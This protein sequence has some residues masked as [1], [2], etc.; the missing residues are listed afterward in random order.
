[1]AAILKN[2]NISAMD[3]P[4]LTKFGT[5]PPTM[6]ANKIL[7]IQKSKMADAVILKKKKNRN[8]SAIKQQI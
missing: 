6:M 2:L 7:W 1:M 3:C 5:S 4:I 8:I